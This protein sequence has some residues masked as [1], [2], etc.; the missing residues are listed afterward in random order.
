MAALVSVD[1]L[2]KEGDD[3]RWDLSNDVELLIQSSFYLHLSTIVIDK[4]SSVGA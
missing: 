4:I 2:T 3:G 1:Y